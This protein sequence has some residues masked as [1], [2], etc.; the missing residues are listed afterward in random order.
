MKT[1]VALSEQE[2]RSLIRDVLIEAPVPEG[3][4]GADGDDFTSQV[5]PQTKEHLDKLISYLGKFIN[6]IGNAG[7]VQFRAKLSSHIMASPPQICQSQ[8]TEMEGGAKFLNYSVPQA[9]STSA[10]S[11]ALLINLFNFIACAFALGKSVSVN[12]PGKVRTLKPTCSLYSLAIGNDAYVGT[13]EQN[14][15]DIYKSPDIKFTIHDLNTAEGQAAYIQNVITKDEVLQSVTQGIK[16]VEADAGRTLLMLDYYDDVAKEKVKSL[17]TQQIA[18]VNAK[19]L[20]YLNTYN[21]AQLQYYLYEPLVRPDQW[22]SNPDLQDPASSPWWTAWEA[23]NIFARS[24]DAIKD[25]P[26]QNA[27]CAAMV[28][29]AARQAKKGVAFRASEKSWSSELQGGSYQALLEEKSGRNLR[30]FLSEAQI[31]RLIYAALALNEV[32]SS[33]LAAGAQKVLGVAGDLGVPGAGVASRAVG[34]LAGEAEPVAAAAGA[35]ARSAPEIAGAAADLR[36]G[37]RIENV[38]LPQSATNIIIRT[39]AAA[40]NKQYIQSIGSKISREIIDTLKRNPNAISAFADKIADAVSAAAKRAA[41]AKGFS[42][43]KVDAIEAFCR[44]SAKYGVELAFGKTDSK[45]ALDS[46]RKALEDVDNN[47]SIGIFVTDQAFLDTVNT[48][49]SRDSVVIADAIN[50]AIE[51]IDPSLASSAKASLDASIIPL[52][53]NSKINLTP[54]GEMVVADSRP[55]SGISSTRYKPSTILTAVRSYKQV[56]EKRQPIAQASP[57]AR[58]GRD[59]VLMMT[60]REDIEAVNSQIDLLTAIVDYVTQGSA[61]GLEAT[62]GTLRAQMEQLL[63]PTVLYMRKALNEIQ[64]NKIDRQVSAEPGQGAAQSIGD[65]ISAAIGGSTASTSSFVDIGVTANEILSTWRRPGGMSK[66]SAVWQTASLLLFTAPKLRA[67]IGRALI[68]GPGYVL[69]KLGSTE[70]GPA[71]MTAGGFK[72]YIGPRIVGDIAVF[73]IL[74]PYMIEPALKNDPVAKTLFAD[75]LVRGGWTQFGGIA[76]LAVDAAN[77]LGRD[78]VNSD[79][80]EYMRFVAGGNAPDT[81]LAL[82]QNLMKNQLALLSDAD[83]VQIFRL[84]A[85]D[86]NLQKFGP[87]AELLLKRINSLGG[88]FGD[89]LNLITPETPEISQENVSALLIDVDTAAKEIA[90]L[91]QELEK[92]GSAV[93][94]NQTLTALKQGRVAVIS[95]V[96]RLL[97]NMKPTKISINPVNASSTIAGIKQYEAVLT[98][99]YRRDLEASPTGELFGWLD[100]INPD[101]LFYLPVYM[102]NAIYPVEVDNRAGTPSDP[103]TLTKLGAD[104][105]YNGPGRRQDFGEIDDL[106]PLLIQ[107]VGEIVIEMGKAFGDIYAI[108]MLINPPAAPE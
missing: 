64:A 61:M 104:A 107:D 62:R 84:A 8:N 21:S 85:P 48:S 91:G 7:S 56:L 47:G 60:G 108:N 95:Q 89:T 54:G 100:S 33:K 72:K 4:E 41:D 18:A 98:S 36:S 90:Q 94:D 46:A 81:M 32:D 75:I 76:R 6:P 9:S 83:L 63:E 37:G 65:F 14:V 25:G 43:D 30:V 12:A 2:L 55:G 66:A 34:A 19:M 29:N 87:Y 5:T 11:D 86:Q 45:P 1:K 99:D 57:Q 69:S 13:M 24:I 38:E 10:G 28:L 67:D 92:F 15:V 73:G 71:M 31:K 52:L 23:C 78:L 105:L 44:A 68:A 53:R 16:Q 88:E 20:E 22:I 58:G 101:N 106:D 42:T 102:K 96:L 80:D 79:V 97:E 59:F 27:A 49:V 3:A 82:F 39:T 50:A 77:E 40:D 51:T 103:T 17:L 93:Q 70:W 35:T 74:W 26:G